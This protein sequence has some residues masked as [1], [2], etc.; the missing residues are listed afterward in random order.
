V[1]PDQALIICRFVV[2]GCALLLWGAHVYLWVGV[3]PALAAKLQGQLRTIT[4]SAVALLALAATCKIPLQAAILGN[5]WSDATNLSLIHDLIMDTRSG[6]ALAVQMALAVLL[7]ITYRSLPA[8]RI[9]SLTCWAGLLLASLTISGH[10]AMH[11]GAFGLL[12]QMNDG[13]HVLA[14]GAWFGALFPVFLLLKS[15][16]GQGQWD[17]SISALMRFSTL[18]H[19]AVAL[20]LLTGVINSGMILGRFWPDLT[21]PYQ[22]LLLLKIVVASVMVGLA[23]LN[24]YGFVPRMAH[25]CSQALRLLRL[26]TI[27]EIGLG[28]LAI[29]LVA[30][31][32]VMEPG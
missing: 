32:G 19:G 21:V 15:K 28:I 2:D 6:L 1:T 23:C 7:A 30:A 14:V 25:D 9:S 5:G 27:L 29:A 10:A 26:G 18:G 22:R 13:L 16:P 3:S 8:H 17:A 12:H 24:R 31:F 11:S 20:T 4:A